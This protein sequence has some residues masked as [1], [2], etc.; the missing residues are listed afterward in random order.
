MGVVNVHERRFPVPVEKAGVLMDALA[1]E[2]DPLWPRKKWPSVRLDR[3]LGVGASGGHGPIRYSVA[4]YLIAMRLHGFARLS[5]PLLYQ[6][7][8]YLNTS[9]GYLAE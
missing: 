3:P 1:T 8:P 2:E 5:W 7:P 6:A 9:A 4:A